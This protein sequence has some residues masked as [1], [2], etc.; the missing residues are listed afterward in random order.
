MFAKYFS[1]NVRRKIEIV[2]GYAIWLMAAG[3]HVL[4]G[5]LFAVWIVAEGLSGL[6][7]LLAVTWA[8]S[9]IFHGLCCRGLKNV[10]DQPVLRFVLPTGVGVSV[11]VFS[12]LLSYVLPIGYVVLIGFAALTLMSVL[13][14]FGLWVGW[15]LNLLPKLVI[16]E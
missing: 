13:N 3:F 14:G 8:F 12:I 2:Y 16:N 1:L 6:S 11:A 7:A 4:F 9:G 10:L 15:K 5:Y